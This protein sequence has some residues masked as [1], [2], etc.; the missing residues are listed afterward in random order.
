MRAAEEHVAFFQEIG[1]VVIQLAQLE[2]SLFLFLSICFPREQE[3]LI[4]AGYIAMDGFRTKLN[5]VSN[6]MHEK[7]SDKRHLKDWDDVAERLA[8]LSTSRNK[9]AHWRAIAIPEHPIGRRY[10]L[11]PWKASKTQTSARNP[12]GA[13]YLRDINS[14]RFHFFAANI[15]LINL[16]CRILN[17]KEAVD[18]G[19][20]KPM[21]PLTLKQLSKDLQT[22]L[23]K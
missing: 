8:T 22:L 16:R 13:L 7:L 4:Y 1:I 20:E 12:R 2:M 3:Q 14:I 6:I 9:I 23:R 17:V 15:T 10:C 11:V 21:K 5:F 19:A 18:K